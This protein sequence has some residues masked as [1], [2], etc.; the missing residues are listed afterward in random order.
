MKDYKAGA[1]SLEYENE[2]SETG[3]LGKKYGCD[4]F[5]TEKSVEHTQ[6]YQ[7]PGT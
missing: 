7:V 3:I 2:E 5:C 6:S 4:L 1:A